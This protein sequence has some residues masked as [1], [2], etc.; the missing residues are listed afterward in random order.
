MSRQPSSEEGSSF[1][2]G[3][4]LGKPKQALDDDVACDALGWW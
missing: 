3:F 4:L 2:F 1:F